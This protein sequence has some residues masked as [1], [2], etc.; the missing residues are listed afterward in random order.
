M[1]A[2]DN[3]FGV[4]S[5]R[6]WPRFWVLLSFLTVFGA[7]R[8]DILLD[9]RYQ[10]DAVG[11]LTGVIDGLNQTA[12]TAWDPLS[13]LQT[14]T[15][16]LNQTTTYGYDPSDAPARVQAPNGAVTT[17]SNDGFGQVRA[18]ASPDRG[19]TSYVYDPAG[20]WI[21]QT[22]ARGAR[23]ETAYDALNRPIE[24]R[25]YRPD[26][27]LEATHRYTWDRAP[28]SLGR[29]DQLDAGP[30]ALAFDY[31]LAGH[32]IARAYS[33]G[34]VTLAVHAQYD[35]TT[36]RLDSLTYPSG[37]VIQYRYDAAGRVSELTWDGQAIAD[38]PQYTAFGAVRALRLANGLDHRRTYDTAGRIASY[39]LADEPVHIT[40]DTAGR[41]T[42]LTPTDPARHQQFSYD[43]ADRLTGYQDAART[44]SYVYDANGNRQSRTQNGQLTAY[45]YLANSNRLQSINAGPIT[46]DAAGNLTLDLT[47]QYAHDSTRRLTQLAQ[48]ALL[49]RYEYNGLGERVLKQVGADLCHFVYDEAGHLLG[50]YDS[51]GQP[52]AEYA[53]L[54]DLPVAYR[55]YRQ[56]DGF[57][58]TEL[59]AVEA[60]HLGTP[61]VL[62]DAG[63]H[64]RWRW[65]SAPFGDT[66][67]E[68]NPENLGTLTFNLRFPGQYYDAESG[69]H[70]NFFRD[71]DPQTGRYVQSDPVGLEGGVNTY[72]YV[73][74]NPISRSDPLGLFWQRLVLI[75]ARN[76]P[77]CVPLPPPTPPPNRPIPTTND[78]GGPSDVPCLPPTL[79]IP[80]V[81]PVAPPD[82]P[83]SN[84]EC[85]DDDDGC[86]ELLEDMLLLFKFIL[87]QINQG[88]DAKML[89]HGYEKNAAEA[90]IICPRICQ[91][92]PRFRGYK[93]D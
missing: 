48:G 90:C 74:G 11:N 85:D 51:T 35:P 54:G 89:V 47:R 76:P 31:D 29:L 64:L 72:G 39:T 23:V 91:D 52:L 20:N 15:N 71:Y 13:R 16:P 36:G 41:L 77:A 6:F 30:N 75:C 38:Q 44:E 4:F 73:G 87:S 24:R 61:R 3:G 62:T 66:P 56:V 83:A 50:E 32:V 2:P 58:Q 17:W 5:H 37:G 69:L 45:Q 59:Y 88:K 80:I 70:Y 28:R 55:V 86:D 92:I 43:A 78:C 12:R 65:T 42:A 63:Q 22:D 26:Q 68:E 57:T 19:A 34:A 40:Y 10:Y 60:D 49:T 27:T 18:E 1:N 53:W 25:F 33:R 8:A 46:H 81:K 7:A 93:H 84:D 67:P 9:T 21:Q 14:Q 79:P 82:I